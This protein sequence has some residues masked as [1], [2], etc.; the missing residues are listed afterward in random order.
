MRITF[1]CAGCALL[2]TMAF[3][4]K[5]ASSAKPPPS[6][7]PPTPSKAFPMKAAEMPPSQSELDAKAAKDINEKNADAEFEKLKHEI[8][9]GG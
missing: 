3:G 1:R 5:E 9:G 8:E 4:C 2:L 7:P 6:A